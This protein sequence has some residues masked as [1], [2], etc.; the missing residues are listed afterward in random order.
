[1]WTAPNPRPIWVMA[2]T[3]AAISRS[4]K[5]FLLTPSFVMS[6]LTVSLPNLLINAFLAASPT[7]AD[8]PPVTG[9]NRAGVKTIVASSIALVIYGCSAIVCTMSLSATVIKF[10]IIAS[11]NSPISFLLLAVEIPMISFLPLLKGTL[12]KSF[13]FLLKKSMKALI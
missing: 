13:S 2:G 1:M 6:C 11:R 12:P 5:S 4:A 7:R 8:V 3:R 10:S 9:A